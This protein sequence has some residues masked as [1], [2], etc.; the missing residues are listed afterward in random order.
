[1]HNSVNEDRKVCNV[2]GAGF[3]LKNKLPTIGRRKGIKEITKFRSVEGY[4]NVSVI[5]WFCVSEA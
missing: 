1:M 5:A 2:Y 4:G 3:R